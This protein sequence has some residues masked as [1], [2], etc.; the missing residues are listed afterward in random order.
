MEEVFIGFNKDTAAGITLKA[1]EMCAT[2]SDDDT[3][4]LQHV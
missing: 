2:N 3:D 1:W 4:S